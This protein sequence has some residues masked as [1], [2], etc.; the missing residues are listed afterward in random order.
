MMETPGRYGPQLLTVYEARARGREYCQ[1]EGSDHY[2]GSS[3]EPLDLIISQGYAEGFCLGGAI[4]Y[5]S[6]YQRTRELGDLRK[7]VDMLHILC[8]VV[9]SQTGDRGP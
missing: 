1:T 7:A 5:A 3:P 2:Q 6:R 9:L 8:G 4:K